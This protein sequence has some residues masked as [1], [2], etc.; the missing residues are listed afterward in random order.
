M[1]IYYVNR[2]IQLHGN[3]LIER[4][5]EERNVSSDRWEL[6]K[7]S[8]QLVRFQSMPVDKDRLRRIHSNT[9]K[10]YGLNQ[11]KINTSSKKFPNEFQYL[12]A[13]WETD[14]VHLR[15]W[16]KDGIANGWT[17]IQRQP[18]DGHCHSVRLVITHTAGTIK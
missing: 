11:K 3:Q 12:A 17:I 16:N 18:V 7:H 1:R 9:W 4:N 15:F 14:Y 5:V 10:I 2:W 6:H 13:N 8:C